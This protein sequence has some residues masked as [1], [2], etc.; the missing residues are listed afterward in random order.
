MES[1][2]VENDFEVKFEHNFERLPGYCK[3]RLTSTDF[4]S[5]HEMRKND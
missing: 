2:G 5:K 1:I 4:G 3:I